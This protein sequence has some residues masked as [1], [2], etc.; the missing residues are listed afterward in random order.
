[1][2]NS[3]FR[4]P[5]VNST[6]MKPKIA[7]IRIF[8][9]L[10]LVGLSHLGA[11]QVLAQDRVF[12]KQGAVASGKIQEINRSEVTIEVRG[13]KQKL[14]LAEVRKITFGDEP[15]GLDRARELFAQQQYDQVL[16][17]LKK[18]D[19][20][21]VKNPL[22]AQDIEFYRFYSEGKLGLT[23]SG[24][25]KEKAAAGLVGL[26]RK[27][28]ESHHMFDL[29]ELL[30]DLAVAL[31]KPDGASNYYN[32]LLKSPSADTKARGV[33]RLALLEL[34]QGKNAEARVR[35]QQLTGAPAN[36]PEMARLKSLGEVGLAVCDLRDGNAQQ[37]LDQLKQMV[38]KYDSTDQEL[39]ARIYN[40]QGACFTALNQDNLAVLAYLRTD[41]LF[42]SDADAHAEALYQLT[43]LWPKIGEPARAA[44]SRSRLVAQYAGS[45]W[46]NKN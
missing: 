42:F 29:S 19:V 35:F 6:S 8:C 36:S 28:G 1:M 15:S 26:A 9:A 4:G 11:S 22:V 18:I 16:D 24:G 2:K 31:G 23:G 32:L 46:A 39:F 27:N 17:E 41:L 37:A 14:P 33:Y 12:P 7:L 44:D 20:T 25:D 13:T 30:G 10:S 3:E 38:E 43:K 5:V 45:L 34:G 40:A 21:A